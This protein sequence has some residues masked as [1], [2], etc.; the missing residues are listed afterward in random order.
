M[1][2]ENWC[3]IM[4]GIRKQRCRKI[5]AEQ[6]G[7]AEFGTKGPQEAIWK[8]SVNR[9]DEITQEMHSLTGRLMKKSADYDIQLI[10]VVRDRS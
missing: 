4:E 7:T 10:Y 3:I 2:K 8:M 6:G 1:S 9:Q 5:T